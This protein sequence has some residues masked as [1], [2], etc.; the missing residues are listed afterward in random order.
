MGS[1]DVHALIAAL[2]PQSKAARLGELMP[3][4]EAKLR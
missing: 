1:N 4:I 2:T 3:A